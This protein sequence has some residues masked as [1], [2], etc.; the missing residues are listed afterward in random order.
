MKPSIMRM[1]QEKKEGEEKVNQWL[2]AEGAK[3][4]PNLPLIAK[5]IRGEVTWRDF[6]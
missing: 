1:Y 5:L 6:A 4:N 3:S 2:K